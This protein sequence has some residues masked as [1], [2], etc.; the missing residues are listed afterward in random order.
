MSVQVISKIAGGDPPSEKPSYKRVFY[1]GTDT[2]YNGYAMCY[3]RA[4]GTAANAEWNRASWVAKPASG[5]LDN[6]AGFIIGVPGTGKAGPGIFKIVD[7]S[8][9]QLGIG[10]AGAA[11]TIG[12]V[13]GI[14]NGSYYLWPSMPTIATARQTTTAAGE[15]L[16]ENESSPVT[17]AMA[18]YGALAG[19][20][21]AYALWEDCPWLE[22]LLDPTKGS[23]YFNNFVDGFQ[24]FT[25][26]S[27]T[28]VTDW[29]QT[30]VTSGL[31]QYKTDAA[32]DAHGVLRVS[33]EAYASADDGITVMW[34]ATP[35]I[36][37]DTKTLWFEA[38]IKVTGAV[39]PDQFFV[40]LCNTIT[41]MHPNGVID[42]TVDKIGFYSHSGSTTLKLAFITSKAAI[43]AAT[44][45]AA[46]IAQNTWIKVGF[47]VS[48]SGSVQTVTPYVNG[49]AGTAHAT[50][51]SVPTA[52]T[53]L[54]ICLA[55]HVDQTS[56]VAV[57]DVDWIRIAQLR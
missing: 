7:K 9:R 50:A 43:Q 6:F 52:L 19:E 25:G 46:T 2:L 23:T 47:K 5:N 41:S 45:T 34:R 27:T 20:G 53:G 18:P 54:G 22:M 28:E 32:L 40:G 37:E 29:I 48:W 44:A 30:E 3:Q 56:T 35:W 4:Y 42:D 12:A 31:T 11:T 55:A 49:V 39:T 57:L 13:L 26:T 15:I 1:N 8:K 51:A 24:P 17:P 14:I 38:R 10:Y 16:V 33:S 21:P 36:T